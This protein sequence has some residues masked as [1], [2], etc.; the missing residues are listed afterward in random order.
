MIRTDLPRTHMAVVPVNTL[1]ARTRSALDVAASLA[2]G[3]LAI[4]VRDVSASAGDLEARWPHEAP[5]VPLCIIEPASHG[6]RAAFLR[7]I[8]KLR[9]TRAV[10][11]VTVVLPR[12]QRG[13]NQRRLGWRVSGRDKLRLS[14]ALRPRVAVVT[15]SGPGV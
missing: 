10:E 7:A 8:D 2:P 5:G 6:W 15:D 11:V 13:M 3:V 4:H 14:L 12:E 9:T 1:D